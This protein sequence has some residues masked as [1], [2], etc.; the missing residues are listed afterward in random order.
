MINPKV[1]VIIPVYNAES[2]IS[3]CVE[4]VFDQDYKNIECIIINDGSTDKTDTICQ[5]ICDKNHSVKYI[6]TSNHGVSHSRNIGLD[7]ATGD[8]IVFLDS[9]DFLLDESISSR[10]NKMS[11]DSLVICGLCEDSIDN[12]FVLDK[13]IFIDDIQFFLMDLFYM[14]RYGYQGYSVNKMYSAKILRDNNIR[15]NEEIY[16][17]EDRL[18]VFEYALKCSHVYY[19]DKVLYCYVHTSGSAMGSVKRDEYNHKQI[20]ELF[21][22]TKML[23]LAPSKKIR[24]AI[25]YDCFRCCCLVLNRMP[26]DR[27]WGDDRKAVI[28]L[29][30]KCF[31]H[32]TLREWGIETIVFK[33]KMLI[34]MLFSVLSIKL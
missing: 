4:S 30:N 14:K 5:L 26:R 8:F 17:N 34:R 1:S 18:F 32:Y 16:Y 21:A 31:W 28:K 10:V 25:E 19:V 29:R 22:F 23:P 3:K 2:T 9:D 15:F 11:E 33:A 6:K 12:S 27:V 24:N 13:K 20:T 7:N